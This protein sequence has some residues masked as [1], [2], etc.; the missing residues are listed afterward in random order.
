MSQIKCISLSKIRLDFQPAEVL[1][2]EKVFEYVNALKRRKAL[3]V[4]Q[5][6]FDGR[7]YFLQDGFHRVE[8][9][10]RCGLKTLKAEITPGTIEDM[11]LEFQTSL[12]DALA[13]FRR[14]Q[15]ED[16]TK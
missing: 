1:D 2:E 11:E 9:A 10:K 7:N 8:A 16:S 12:K 6:R 13:Q 5:L 14:E 4:I 3:P 15:F